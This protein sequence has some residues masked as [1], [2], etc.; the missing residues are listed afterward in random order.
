MSALPHLDKFDRPVSL[1]PVRAIPETFMSGNDRSWL[2][3]IFLGKITQIF[4]YLLVGGGEDDLWH[5]LV[6]HHVGLHLHLAA[7]GG[8]HP[9]HTC[10]LGEAVMM[11]RT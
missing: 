4:H 3:N 8:R 10:H 1:P 5:E 11:T 6:H 9:R 7:E 2:Q